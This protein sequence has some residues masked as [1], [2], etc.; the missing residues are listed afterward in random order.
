MSSW[1]WYR[2]P[3]QTTEELLDLD[4]GQHRIDLIVMTFEDLLLGKLAR[5]GRAN[6]STAE[7]TVLA[8]E[9]LEREVNNGGFHQFFSNSSVE[10]VSVLVDSLE[11]SGCP[12][13]AAIAQRAIDTLELPELSAAAIEAAMQT[14]NDERDAKLH[15]CDEAF[16]AYEEDLAGNLFNY[17]RT[18][19]PSIR[20][21]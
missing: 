5:E 10:F 18:N 3:A 13:A 1:P 11:R 2:T 17:M 21:P 12:K 9:A 16:F 19:Q 14:D 8:I 20:I 6:L 4:D 7:I 15:E